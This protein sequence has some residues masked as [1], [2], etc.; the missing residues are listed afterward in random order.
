MKVL[1]IKKSTSAESFANTTLIWKSEIEKIRSGKYTHVEAKEQNGTIIHGPVDIKV[2]KDILQQGDYVSRK[3]R[4]SGDEFFVIA[5]KAVTSRLSSITKPIVNM[6]AKSVSNQY[7][8]ETGVTYDLNEI[9]SG[10]GIIRN[11]K[12]ISNPLRKK[13]KTK[14]QAE[15]YLKNVLKAK[16]I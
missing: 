13:H 5:K 3:N 7:A 4:S 6:P 8:D 1:T 16:P 14:L 11:G 10:Y 2:Y 15:T 12:T 9:D